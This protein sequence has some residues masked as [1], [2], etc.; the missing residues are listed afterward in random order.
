M[1][2]WPHADSD[3]HTLLPAVEDDFIQLAEAILQHEAL[4]VICRDGDHRRHIESRLHNTTNLFSVHFFE[5]PYNDTWCRDFGPITVIH[6]GQPVLLDF[7]FNGWG[8][9]YDATLDNQI[10]Q[11]LQQQNF[12]R[13]AK[14][15]IDFILE[16]G[17]IESNGAGTLLT[18]GS[19]LLNKNRNHVNKQEIEILLN[20]HLHTHRILWLKHGQLEGDDTDSHID[21][22]AR[23]V[24]RDAIAYLSC[25]NPSDVHFSGLQKM[26]REL[27][28]FRQPDSEPYRLIPLPL[29]EPCV[30][31]L[32]GRR[33]P[34]SYLNFLII[35]N[36]VLVPK[37]DCEADDIAQQALR[38]C[39]PGR[40]IIAINSQGFIEQNGGIHCLTMQLPRDT[41]NKDL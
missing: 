3:W 16:G 17:S 20:Q 5:T 33:L 41:L 11:K 39:F 21:N 22:L 1:L 38:Q 40:K 24:A 36:A 15:E 18:T 25:D 34:A 32:D 10:T 27:R 7:Q 26:Q 2:A 13:A 14:L 30:S 31:R 23:F 9:R 19:C 37:F 6:N 12:F 4:L 8:N 28:D 29:P 35:N